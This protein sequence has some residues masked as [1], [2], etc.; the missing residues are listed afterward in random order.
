MKWKKKI[1]GYS[2]MGWAGTVAGRNIKEDPDDEGLW[3]L[4]CVFQH[5]LPFQVIDDIH[6]YEAHS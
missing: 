1:Y 5:F 4:R 2:T 3:M 6:M